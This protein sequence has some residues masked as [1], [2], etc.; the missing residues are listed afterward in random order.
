MYPSSIQMLQQIKQKLNC[1]PKPSFNQLDHECSLHNIRAFTQQIAQGSSRG[2]RSPINHQQSSFRLSFVRCRLWSFLTL[3]RMWDHFQWWNHHSRLARPSH[4]HVAHIPHPWWRQQRHKIS[5]KQRLHIWSWNTIIFCK[6]HLR[7]RKHWATNQ[8]LS[9]YHGLPCHIHMAQ[10]H[11]C[12]LLP[13]VAKPQLGKSTE[14]HQNST[15]NRNGP[16]GPK[17]S[18]HPLNAC[19]TRN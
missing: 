6:Q 11:W 3:T 8:V 17:K 7:M 5:D 16:L 1:Q 15:W 10:G 4:K 14:I 2:S 18:R 19:H 13:R 9:C 12:R